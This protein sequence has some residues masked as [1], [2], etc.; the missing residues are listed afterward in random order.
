MLEGFVVAQVS[1]SRPIVDRAN[2]AGVFTTDTAGRLDVLRCRLRLTSDYHQAEARHVN[3]DRD[4]VGRQQYIER[5]R[6]ELVAL[7]AVLDVFEDDRVESTLQQIKGLR[8]RRRSQPRSQFLHGV[9]R[10]ERAVGQSSLDHLAKA[11]P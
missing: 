6:N 8:D 7:L 1:R 5:T 11:S 9:R 10:V 2:E 3:A 4:H